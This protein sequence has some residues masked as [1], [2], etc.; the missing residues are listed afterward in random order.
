MLFDPPTPAQGQA[1][2]DLAWIVLFC[3]A[4]FTTVFLVKF[5]YPRVRRLYVSLRKLLGELRQSPRL[6]RWSRLVP[7]H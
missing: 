1:T 3:A 2:H 5:A 4:T 6:K 7:F